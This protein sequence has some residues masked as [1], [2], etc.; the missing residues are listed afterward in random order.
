MPR[1]LAVLVLF[2]ACVRGISPSG[3]A[4]LVGLTVPLVSAPSFRLVL[5]ANLAGRPA[6]VQLDP[7]VELSLVSTGCPG[8]VPLSAQVRVVDP[9]APE[10]TYRLAR[11]GGLDLGSG[12]LK[13]FDAGVTED[14]GCVVIL[15]G[16]VL[17]GL[18]L[19]VHVAAREV[20]FRPSASREAWLAVMPS[21]EEVEVVTLTREPRHDWPLVTVRVT[22]ADASFTGALLFSTREPRTRIFEASARAA[23]LRPGLELFHGLP[24]PEGLVLPRSL[25]GL[26]GFAVDRVE[27]SKGV[28]VANVS[29]DL[30]PG[31]PP[32]LPHGVLGAD[33]WARFDAVIDMKE[34][35]V[36]LHRPRVLTSG[37]RTLCERDGR[38][39]EDVCFEV[40]QRQTPGATV[41]GMATWRPLPEG[42]RI[43]FDFAGVDPPC[44]IGYSFPPTDRG[45][46]TLH[47]LPWERLKQVMPACAASL[48]SAKAVEPGLFQDGPLEE[49][50]GVC[51]YAQDIASA[52][53]TCECQ[54]TRGNLDEDAERELLNLYRALLEKTRPASQPEPKDP[55]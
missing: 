40:T 9:F 48:A 35:L 45:R 43:T 20:R 38:L 16:D 30:E 41:V 55:D 23:G 11:V 3:S 22:Q 28:G 4:S 33:V 1:L 21:N 25:E 31:A 27:L 44:R 12:R 18:A 47:E 54:P 19:E 26:R 6:T 52:R 24:L 53:V 36:V 34:G 39:G 29:V 50:P 49:C 8:L 13:D 14:E 37:A 10:R 5:A 7:G 2:T 46:S 42:G 15:G 17:A 51:A 32:H